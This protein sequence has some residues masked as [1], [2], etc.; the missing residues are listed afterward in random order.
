MEILSQVAE[1]MQGVLTKTA[2]MIGRVLLIVYSCFH[3]SKKFSVLITWVGSSEIIWRP[4]SVLL[5]RRR[6]RI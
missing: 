2:D 6:L 3:E 4:R 5:I 1:G